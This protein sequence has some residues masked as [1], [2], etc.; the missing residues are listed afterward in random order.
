MG[1]GGAAVPFRPGIDDL[2]Q[3]TAHRLQGVNGERTGVLK[4]RFGSLA[5]FMP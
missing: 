3:R 1:I 2:P 4:Y 5:L